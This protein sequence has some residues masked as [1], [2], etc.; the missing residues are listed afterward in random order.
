M[1]KRFGDPRNLVKQDLVKGP[2]IKNWNADGLMHLC[3]LM[4]KCETS[5]KAWNKS[6]LLDNDEIMLGLFQSLSYRVRAK[7]VSATN[8]RNKNGTFQELQESVKLAA[9]EAES[10]YGKLMTQNKSKLHQLG[11][12]KSFCAA[13]Q[14]LSK[15]TPTI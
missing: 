2:P 4:Y 14:R 13:M 1:D 9:S 8:E 11:R 15:P 5:F 7:L 6:Y 3:D 10:A 12:P